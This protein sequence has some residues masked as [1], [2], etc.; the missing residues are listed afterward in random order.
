V[1]GDAT[2]ATAEKGSRWLA[3]AQDE[4]ADF[5]RAVRDRSHPLPVDHH[6]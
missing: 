4:I 2:A 1:T 3:R 6:R 5:I